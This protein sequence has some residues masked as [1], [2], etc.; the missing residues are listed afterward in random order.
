MIVSPNEHI[1]HRRQLDG[2]HIGG[3][4]GSKKVSYAGNKKV[5]TYTYLA[6]GAEYL[7]NLAENNRN[8]EFYT[9]MMSMV[10]TAFF[11]EA[12]FNHLGSECL[13]CW[14]EVER[15]SP[16]EKLQLLCKHFKIKFDFGK[17]PYQSI[18]K[19]F[20]FRN[21]VAHGKTESVT[22]EWKNPLGYGNTIDA[23][24]TKWEKI[25]KPKEARRAYTDGIEIVKKLYKKAGFLG[26]PLLTMAEA[27]GGTT[28]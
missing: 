15:R 26:E 6:K 20:V 22:N 16:E 27:F 13:P 2:E 9:S 18:K 28:V 4:L 12:F 23:L 3:N 11:L 8:G 14:N 17:R 1:A 24:Q 10:A 21:L 5:F 7:L 25:C 19:V